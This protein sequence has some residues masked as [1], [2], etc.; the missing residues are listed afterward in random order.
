M[1]TAEFV[2]K[3]DRISDM[4]PGDIAVSLDRKRLFVCAYLPD[5]NSNAYTFF[6]LK[7]LDD[8]YLHRVT[9]DTP[10]RLLAKGDKFIVTV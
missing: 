4:R 6:D 1:P 8:W 7:K 3:H 5:K 2:E 10:L 9:P